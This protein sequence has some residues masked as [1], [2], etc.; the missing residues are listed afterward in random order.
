[1]KILQLYQFKSLR[2]GK[3]RA[4]FLI[5]VMSIQLIMMSAALAPAQVTEEYS[6]RVRD[7]DNMVDQI[8]VL[9]QRVSVLESVQRQHTSSPMHDETAALLG[10]FRERMAVNETQVA[11]IS[12]L[13]YAIGLGIIGLIIEAVSRHLIGSKSE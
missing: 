13:L 2:H 1:M 11:T 8:S 12:W 9:K 3:A 10:L 5:T 6:R 4:W 7:I